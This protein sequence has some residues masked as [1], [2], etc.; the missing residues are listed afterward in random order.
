MGSL[1]D[2][3]YIIQTDGYW[4]VEAHDVD[5][6]KGYISVSAKGI[7]NG[8]SNQPNDGADF[9][10]DTYNPNYSGS[11]I[12]YTQTSGLQEA[13]N[14]IVNNGIGTIILND[15]IYDVT[16]APLHTDPISSQQYKVY[17][18][19]VPYGNDTLHISIIGLGNATLGISE[20]SNT[21]SGG[22]VIQSLDV[23]TSTNP[24]LQ[25]IFG[26]FTTSSP[27]FSNV[28]LFID[29]ITFSTS[30]NSNNSLGCV[31]V[32][33][34]GDCEFGRLRCY[35]SNGDNTVPNNFNQA[36]GLYWMAGSTG[37]TNINAIEIAIQGYK[38]GVYSGLVHTYIAKLS[39]N[40]CDI[41]L[42]STTSGY[43]GYSAYISKYEAQN[44]I[45]AILA[46][47]GGLLSLGIGL[48]DMA[49]QASSGSYAYQ[50][51]V[52]LTNASIVN[53]YSFA[54]GTSGITP[55]FDMGSAGGIIN[56]HRFLLN[57][58]GT[59]Y[60]PTVSVPTVPASGTAQS[61]T[62]PYPVNVYLYGGTVTVIDYTPNGGSATQV[63]TAG[64]ATV[65]LN[66]GDSITLTYSAAPTWN[67]V[68]V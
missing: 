59:P 11:G 10:P 1:P 56:V 63:G 30:G 46:E 54:L 6:S 36:T 4:F 19:A 22:V 9:G 49:D 34:A 66:P 23:H 62:N 2:S 20:I 58:S 3:K 52:F 15:G 31:D 50:N 47:S 5:P 51:S 57:S 64:P 18:P 28:S 53:I 12:P 61:N 32:H 41:G 17:I 24:I 40:I 42:I 7:I 45:T 35:S 44:T 43:G 29:G 68:A 27:Y 13:I 21:Q 60:I 67:W 25:F 55:V 65:R 16:S 37:G 48:L 39:T 26:V 14:Y 38:Y 33:F 8:L